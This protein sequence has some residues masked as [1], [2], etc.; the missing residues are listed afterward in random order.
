MDNYNKHKF[1][2]WVK[3]RECIQVLK[4]GGL[5]KPWS[6][7]P[8]FQVTYF[9]NTNREH[10]KVTRWMRQN[11]TGSDR[12]HDVENY[13]LARMVNKPES[14]EAMGW[15]WN[16][17]FKDQWHGVMSQKGAW[18]SA[19]IV[20]TNG[21]AIAK[22]EYIG[23]LL[24]RVFEQVPYNPPI[25]VAPTLES[26]HKAL[27]QLQGMGSFMSG[28]VVADLKN[29]EGNILQDATDWKSWAT[30]GPG[31]LRGLTWFHEEQVTPRKFKEALSSARLWC[32]DEVAHL[33]NQNLQ[34]CFC[35]YDKYMRV[36][37][38]T[39]RSKR[40]YNGN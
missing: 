25:G 24:E 37:S 40:K 18:G 32:K 39:G 16:S 33:C 14:L 3:E 22:H 7:D 29:T 12:K 27:M 11:F 21:R 19:Y 8:I 30:H 5:E 36:E 2:Y 28:Q 35:E 1:I 9:C 34:N 4:D 6:I 10:D 20:S 15:P 23:G 31:S 17:F 26:C 13:I 38:N